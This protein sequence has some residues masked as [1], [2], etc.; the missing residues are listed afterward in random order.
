MLFPPEHWELYDLVA[1]VSSAEKKVSSED[2]HLLRRHQPLEHG[3]CRICKEACYHLCKRPLPSVT[4]PKL[5]EA[6]E[7]DALAMHAVMQTG[8][9]SLLY[10]LPGT[11]EV[12]QAVRRWRAE[13]SHRVLF[14]HRRRTK[15]S[16]LMCSTRCAC[17]TGTSG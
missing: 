5:G 2:G 3:A 7:W 15:C 14:H 10:W 16:C 13:D 9:P 17:L 8:N 6:I 1:I 11:L 4:L 12:M